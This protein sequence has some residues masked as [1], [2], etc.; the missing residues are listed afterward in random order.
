MNYSNGYTY[1]YLSLLYI[2]K[3][4]SKKSVYWLII[5]LEYT[6]RLKLVRVCYN[7]NKY[8]IEKRI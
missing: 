8:P 5:S 7:N 3:S 4:K 6:V 1:H 2:I